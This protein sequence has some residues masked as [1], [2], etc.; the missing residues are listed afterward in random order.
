MRDAAVLPRPVLNTHAAPPVI[1]I[2]PLTSPAEQ[3]I[4]IHFR[5][6]YSH[7]EEGD[8]C[9]AALTRHAPARGRIRLQNYVYA[10]IRSSLTFAMRHAAPLACL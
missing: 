5:A 6:T 4:C 3:H 10:C 7:D 8:V 9:F 1:D 2:S